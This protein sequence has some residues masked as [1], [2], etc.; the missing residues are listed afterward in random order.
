MHLNNS[1]HKENFQ[2]I[3]CMNMD[4]YYWLTQVLIPP[5]P[6]SHS[7]RYSHTSARSENCWMVGWWEWM[8]C[9]V[10]LGLPP[11][12][13]SEEEDTSTKGSALPQLVSFILQTQESL[14]H[15]AN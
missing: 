12:G 13:Q 11:L 15:K 3:F 7:R 8:E 10:L 6:V 9:M 14:H 5:Q 1:R 4:K 2:D